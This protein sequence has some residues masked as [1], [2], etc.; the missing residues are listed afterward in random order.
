MEKTLVLIKPDAV[1]KKLIGRILGIYEDNGLNVDKMYMTTVNEA[2][3]AEHYAEHV[4]RDFYPKLVE[5]MMSGPLVAL[6]LS[7]D[8]AISMTRKIN[9]ATN[10][11]KADVLTIRYLFGESVTVNSVHASANKE[12]A[13][14]E[15]EIWFKE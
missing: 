7:G 4:E 10:P 9:G 15:L 12:D 5:F 11:A 3:L 8:N 14:R 2:L 1:S 13:A 6:Q